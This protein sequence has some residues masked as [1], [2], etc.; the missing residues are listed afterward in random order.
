[1]GPTPFDA[2]VAGP[3]SFLGPALRSGWDPGPAPVATIF[4]YD[5]T[6]TAHLR[7]QPERFRD[8]PNLAGNGASFATGPAAAPTIVLRARALSCWQVERRLLDRGVLA[9]LPLARL[10]PADPTLADALLVCATEVTKPAEIALFGRALGDEIERGR[11]LS[12][13]SPG[14]G[15]PA[16]SSGRQAGEVAP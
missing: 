2:S 14:V 13:E 11:Q 5:P 3:E 6:L 10:E 4:T 7:G 1:M 9:G 12:L 8:A 16:G 15:W